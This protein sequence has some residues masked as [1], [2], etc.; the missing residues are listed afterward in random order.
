MACAG[1]RI[2]AV[3]TVDSKCEFLERLVKGMKP[4]VLMQ[5][6]ICVK[7]TISDIKLNKE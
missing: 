6:F 2:R 7:V 1:K 4:A 3:L 5:E